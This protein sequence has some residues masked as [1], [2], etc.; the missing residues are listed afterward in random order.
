MKLGFWFFMFGMGC[1]SDK[2][3]PK[4]D[5]LLYNGHIRIN[6]ERVFP[7]PDF[8]LIFIFCINYNTKFLYIDYYIFEGNNLTN[9]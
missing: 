3:L 1:S 4:A 7:I 5:L 2:T 8:V 9:Q 6:S